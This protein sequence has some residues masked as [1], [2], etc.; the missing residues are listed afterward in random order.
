[1]ALLYSGLVLR[2]IL[3]GGPSCNLATAICIFSHKRPA[4]SS[5][6]EV[7]SNIFK[8]KHLKGQLGPPVNHHFL[9]RSANHQKC[10]SV[11]KNHHN[12]S[13]V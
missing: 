11:T 10:L 3:E 9:N 12:T 2:P 1:M 5:T 4:V 7:K 13:S 8:S 6:K